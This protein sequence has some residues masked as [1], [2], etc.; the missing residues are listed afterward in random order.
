MANFVGMLQEMC[1][2]YNKEAPTYIDEETDLPNSVK[3]CVC[4]L[5]SWTTEGVGNSKKQAR[6]KAAELMLANAKHDNQFTTPDRVTTSINVGIKINLFADK[7]GKEKPLYSEKEK[8]DDLFIVEYKFDGY[9]SVGKG[10]SK[11]VAKEMALEEIAAHF[12]IHTFHENYLKKKERMQET[13]VSISMLHELCQAR[14]LHNPSYHDE[15]VE[16]CNGKTKDFVV[17]CSVND[18]L[19]VSKPNFSKKFAKIEAA[20]LMIDKLNKTLHFDTPNQSPFQ[21]A[22]EH[23][24]P[25]L[26]EKDLDSDDEAPLSKRK[27]LFEN[28][29]N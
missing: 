21:S 7:N 24:T 27:K 22:V 23:D 10:S 28:I 8:E 4:K 19:T 18:L 12:D 1:Q 20:A 5:H 11:K 9:T 3:K 2:K 16:N 6:Q 15:I 26:P 17:S 13:K 14:K 29:L 25:L